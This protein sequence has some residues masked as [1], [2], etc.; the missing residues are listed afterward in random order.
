MPGQWHPEGSDKPEAVRTEPPMPNPQPVA[1]PV[2][3]VQM[4]AP[5]AA[6]AWH[7]LKTPPIAMVLA[8]ITVLTMFA[9]QCVAATCFYLADM[10]PFVS[11]AE[12]KV[13][14]LLAT[15]LMD[16]GANVTVANEDFANRFGT[17]LQKLP[18]TR[19][20]ESMTGHSPKLTHHWFGP[21]KVV[22]LHG[23]LAFLANPQKPMKAPS[24]FHLNHLK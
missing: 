1:P 22:A 20:A 12:I 4:A 13:N 24:W 14:G 10:S 11:V 9:V 3:I 19:Y 15:A 21:Y 16:T 7:W 5:P 8:V 6:P 2:N 23:T 18:P 17:I